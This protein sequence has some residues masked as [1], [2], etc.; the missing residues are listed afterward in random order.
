MS[1]VCLCWEGRGRHT[2]RI[3][4]VAPREIW[5]LSVSPLSET[6][7]FQ[8]V[9]HWERCCSSLKRCD[10]NA[11]RLLFPFDKLA[12]SSFD[13]SMAVLYLGEEGTTLATVC[14][15]VKINK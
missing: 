1:S 3:P 13:S 11:I 12:S 2:Q 10:C 9:L 5:S 8:H 15:C 14:V 6:L 4:L 7:G